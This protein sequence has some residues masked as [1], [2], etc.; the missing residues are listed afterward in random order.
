M[1]KRKATI[2][3]AITLILGGLGAWIDWGNANVEWVWF[4]IIIV[5]TVGITSEIMDNK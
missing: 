4:G 1:I 3:F 5:S 2:C